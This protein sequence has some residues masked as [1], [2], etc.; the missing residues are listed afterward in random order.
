MRA[1]YIVGAGD[2]FPERFQPADG[3][4]I[5]AADAGYRHLQKIGVEPDLIIGDFDSLGSAPEHPNVVVC[6][7]R[8]DD[9]DTLVAVRHAL[10]MGFSRLM[11]FGGTG[12]RLDHTLANVQTLGFA[13][14]RGAEAFLFG[15]TFTL[16]ALTFGQLE[17][18]GYSGGFSVFSLGDR[19]RGVWETGVR[20]PLAEAELTCDF[21]LGVSNA[22]EGGKTVISVREGI[23][24]VFWDG[25]REKPLPQRKKGIKKC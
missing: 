24:V 13:A 8:K 12:G 22:F 5:I 7:V 20:F 17:F 18:P 21:P 11:L 2:F 9:T 4:Y 10:E 25:N 1:C 14:V 16:T 23:L 3:D 19:A 15:D 6:P